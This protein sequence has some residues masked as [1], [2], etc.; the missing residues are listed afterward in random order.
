MNLDDQ[1]PSPGMTSNVIDSVIIP[2]PP[3]KI[4]VREVFSWLVIL[5][6]VGFQFVTNV[7]DFSPKDSGE[8]K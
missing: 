6:V 3:R 1:H 4:T 2:D 5:S 8:Q 7:F